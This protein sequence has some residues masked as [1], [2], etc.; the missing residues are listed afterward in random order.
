MNVEEAK[1]PESAYR[2]YFTTNHDENS[3]NGTDPGMYGDN[4]EN[5]AVLSATLDGMPLIY[6][7]QESILDKQLEFFEKDEIEWKEYAYQPFY[8]MLLNL[9]EDNEALWNGQYGGDLNIFDSPEETFAYKRMK[10]DD[11]VFV[12]LNNGNEAVNVPFEDYEIPTDEST[13][14]IYS[15]QLPPTENN[16]FEVAPNSWLLIANR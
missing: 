12:Y 16:Y 6:N 9:K 13:Y 15:E 4:F 7:G 8:T 2:M 5:F 14:E 10:G 11:W 3:W 1:F